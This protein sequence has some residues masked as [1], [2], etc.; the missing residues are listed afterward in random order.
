MSLENLR[1]LTIAQPMA[2]A[3]VAGPKRVENRSWYPPGGLRG[4][5][6]L[7]IAVHAGAGLWSGG[8]DRQSMV[9]AGWTEMP[10][11]EELPRRAVL[12]VCRV[13]R[14]VPYPGS[15]AGDP[16]ASGPV[17]WVLRDV[18]RFREPIPWR[19]GALGLWRCPDELV[20]LVRE[21]IPDSIVA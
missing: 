7:T 15:L 3:I 14:A 1:G 18:L 17:C 19:R 20:R 16:W 21:A 9:D 12:G 5:W 8:W 10:P 4:L 2:S 13:D 6:D 11:V